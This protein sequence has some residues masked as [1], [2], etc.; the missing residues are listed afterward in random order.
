MEVKETASEGLRHEFTVV[1]AASEFDAKINERLVGLSQQVQMK[2][3]RP[4]KVPT[5]L[6]RKLHGDAVK[7]EVLEETINTTSQQLLEE[8]S[9]RP[10]LQPE[11]EIVKF[12]EGADLEYT[13]KV[14]VLPEIEIGDFSDLKLERWN[15]PVVDSEIDEN[16]QRIAD[17]QKKFEPAKRKD[18]KA[19]QGDSVVVDFIGKVDD[20]A[21]DGGVGEDHQ[22]ELGSGSF[23]PG[24][25]DQLIGAKKEQEIKVK[26]S[27]PE[28]YGHAE[29]A[30]KDAVFDVTV[31]E[32]RVPGKIEIDDAFAES[33]GLENLEALQKAV[34]GQLEEEHKNL[35]RTLLKRRLMDA[36]SERLD[37]EVPLG[38]VEAELAQIAAQPA[39]NAADQEANQEAEKA[40]EKADD[41][42]Q[43]SDQAEHRPIA[44]RRIRLGLLFAEI[45]REHDITVRQDEINRS[46]A[47]RA[48]QLPGQEAMV[49]EYYQKDQN[50]LAQ[51]R[52]PMFEDKIVDFILEMAEVS[53]RESSLEEL[54]K[55][56]QDE[57]APVE[58]KAGSTKKS[59]KG[60]QRKATAKS[61]PSAAR[62][63]STAKAKKSEAA[64][65]DK[66]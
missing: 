53:E 43:E 59:S 30:G 54:T 58:E 27:F 23:I 64:E 14:E 25:E 40:D 38:M 39:D 66:K 35:T 48:R 3:F 29:L 12:D 34:K 63:R 16:L 15:A 4:G 46:I 33:L 45:G 57:S 65:N 19:K 11:I 41:Q 5:S 20:V 10:A 32:V 1:V 9:M 61:K 2:G 56:V 52:A 28:D 50:A 36:L 21:F 37:F 60:R 17:Q 24:F 47:E 13:I 62:A 22:L 8:R 44:E 51:L 31:K 49:Y 18:Y 42:S 7:S 26:V 6:L 55:A